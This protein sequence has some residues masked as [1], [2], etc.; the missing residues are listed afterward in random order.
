MPERERYIQVYE[1]RNWRG[2][3]QWYWRLK[4]GNHAIIAIGGEG[5]NNMGD[6][7]HIADDVTGNRYRI[8]YL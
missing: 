7:A 5:F 3:K 6:A 4:G 1:K 8:D 2:R